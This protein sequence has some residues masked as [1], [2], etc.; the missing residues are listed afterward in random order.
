[1][2]TCTDVF[3]GLPRWLSGKESPGS[4]GDAGSICGLGRCAGG[5]NSKPLQ[6]FF[7]WKIPGTEGPG[8]L[9]SMRSQRVRCNLATEQT[10]IHVHTKIFPV[11]MHSLN[12][13]LVH[14]SGT[15]VETYMRTMKFSIYGNSTTIMLWV[16]LALK[17]YKS[18]TLCSLT[19]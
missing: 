6:Y 7:A 14:F 15:L 19:F 8:K 1:M 9:Q 2:N 17:I 5:G 11:G 13:F 12:V 18:P 16:F 4:A 10:C 3:M